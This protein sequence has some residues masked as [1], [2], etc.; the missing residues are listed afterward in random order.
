[1]FAHLAVLDTAENTLDLFTGSLTLL[2]DRERRS[3][4]YQN[5]NTREMINAIK[6]Q[7]LYDVESFSRS[8]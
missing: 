6:S 1:S 5:N 3:L 4:L 2:F 7:Q 8:S